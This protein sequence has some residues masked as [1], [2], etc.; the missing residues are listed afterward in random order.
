[1]KRVRSA[2]AGAARRLAPVRGALRPLRHP[3]EDLPLLIV[4]GVGRSGTTA[5]RNAIAVCAH[6]DA[7]NR[8][9][10]FIRDLLEVALRNCTLPVRKASMAVTQQEYDLVFRRAILWLAWPQPRREPALPSALCTYTNLDPETASHLVQVFPGA[11]VAYIVRDGIEVVASRM[12]FESFAVDSFETNCQRW[13][14]AGAMAEWIRSHADAG[15]LVRHEILRDPDRRENELAAVLDLVGLA[16]D[17]ACGELLRG[18]A[19]HPTRHAGESEAAAG[20]L[21]ARRERWRAWST[22]EREVFE[23]SCRATMESLGYAIPWL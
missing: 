22:D 19:Y 9:S 14:T 23:R 12:G 13:C 6:V 18:A 5:L 10:N 4:S 21:A 16:H 3:Y 15:R 11:K 2:I 1:V 8:E 7:A 20:D 17:P